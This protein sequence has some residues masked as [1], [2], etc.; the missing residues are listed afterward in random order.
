M[1]SFWKALLVT[2]ILSL[3]GLLAAPP[4]VHTVAQK[5]RLAERLTWIIQPAAGWVRV[6]V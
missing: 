2:L 5:S 1:S 4:E 6:Q 3:R